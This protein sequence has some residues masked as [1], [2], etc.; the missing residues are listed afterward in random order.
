[1]CV[2]FFRL[3]FLNLDHAN[4]NSPPT[5]LFKF[6]FVD[7]LAQNY[8]AKVSQEGARISIIS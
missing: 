5:F 6:N 3:G 8:L 4:S 2:V 1:M 7:L